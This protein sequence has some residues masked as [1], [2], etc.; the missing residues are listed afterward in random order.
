MA[1]GGAC[2]GVLIKLSEEACADDHVALG[3][4]GRLVATFGRCRP[5]SPIHIAQQFGGSF[6]SV[7]LNLPLAYLLSGS[8]FVDLHVQISDVR[9][10]Q[11]Q[12]SPTSRCQH[13]DGV[14]Q[15]LSL[16]GASLLVPPHPTTPCLS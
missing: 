7:M 8:H 15:L 10:T 6:S 11:P 9:E 3:H 2:G 1:L 16:G 5:G 13:L 14:T 12:T 4:L